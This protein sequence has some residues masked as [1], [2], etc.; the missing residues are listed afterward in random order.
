MFQTVYKDFV[1][2]KTSLGYKF[3][4]NTQKHF[5]IKTDFIKTNTIK[6]DIIKQ[7]VKDIKIINVLLGKQKKSCEQFDYVIG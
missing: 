1:L 3:K 5:K 2:L 4:W 6:L 7:N